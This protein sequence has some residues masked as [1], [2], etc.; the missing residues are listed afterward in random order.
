MQFKKGTKQGCCKSVM[1]KGSLVDK[2]PLINPAPS[3]IQ[4]MFWSL[5]EIINYYVNLC[6]LNLYR[7]SLLHCWCSIPTNLYILCC[8][9]NAIYFLPFFLSL[10]LEKLRFVFCVFYLSIFFHSIKFFLCF[11]TF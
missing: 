1:L 6:M 8:L 7:K 5:I 2:I 4:N 3:F 9:A 11:V 10:R